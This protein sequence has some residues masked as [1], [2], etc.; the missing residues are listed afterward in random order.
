MTARKLGLGS[1]GRVF[2]FLKN[3]RSATWGRFLENGNFGNL[4]GLPDCHGELTENATSHAL[5]REAGIRQYGSF[6]DAR[7]PK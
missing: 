6:L 1:L 3:W 5:V 7:N 4:L 2:G